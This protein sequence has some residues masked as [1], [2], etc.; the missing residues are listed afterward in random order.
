MNR[1]FKLYGG[2]IFL[3]TCFV[4]TVAIAFFVPNKNKSKNEHVT[5]CVDGFK[6]YKEKQ[7][8]SVGGGGVV[9]DSDTSK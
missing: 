2:D 6:F 7:L 4:C 9:C 5:H 8:I 3:I 1:L